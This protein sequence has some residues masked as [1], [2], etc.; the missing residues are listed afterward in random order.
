M[1]LCL[2]KQTGRTLL[3]VACFG[4]QMEVVKLLLSL[5]VDINAQDEVSF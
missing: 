5:G 4:K 2:S 3:M 1:S